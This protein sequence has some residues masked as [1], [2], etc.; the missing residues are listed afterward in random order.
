MWDVLA[1][2]LS[3]VLTAGCSASTRSQDETA[4]PAGAAV[5]LE[6]GGHLV[7]ARLTESPAAR[8]LAAMLPLTVRLKDVWGQAKSGRRGAHRPGALITTAGNLPAG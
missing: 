5:V 6:F 4:A 2:H 8:E 7:R 1:V 3:S